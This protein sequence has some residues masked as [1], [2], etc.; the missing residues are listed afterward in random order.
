MFGDFFTSA[1]ALST[2]PVDKPADSSVG[3]Y[4]TACCD[5]ACATLANIWPA[6]LVDLARRIRHLH[7]RCRMAWPQSDRVKKSSAITV[8]STSGLLL[9]TKPVDKPADSDVEIPAAALV[10]QGAQE[11]WREIGQRNFLTLFVVGPAD[12]RQRLLRAASVC[13]ATAFQT[14]SAS[15]VAATSCTRSS[16][17]PRCA[18]IRCG[19]DRAV[20]AIVRL[21]AA[22]ELADACVLRDRPAS[23][24]TP[25][26]AK[27]SS[28]ASS[29]RLCSRVLAEAEA[30]IDD[31]ASSWRCRPSRRRRCARRGSDA[32]R[33]PR[34]RTAA[35]PASSAARRACASAPPARRARRR[36]RARPRGAARRRR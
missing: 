11:V 3:S 22:G 8:P 13:A 4:R 5:G 7:P 34:R 32:R 17:A 20:H 27:R 2:M 29:A 31:D 15:T 1:L 24:G 12:G 6:K 30:G 36:H 10:R 18:A 35:R 25:S 23:T 26:S 19:G 14:F 16:F 33:R 9:S 28:C 21:V